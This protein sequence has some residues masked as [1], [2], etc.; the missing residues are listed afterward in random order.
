M[1]WYLIGGSQE[2]V[3]SREQSATVVTQVVTVNDVLI[4]ATLETIL[5]N[6][7]C[8]MRI[9][10]SFGADQGMVLNVLVDTSTVKFDSD[11]TGA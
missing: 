3:E 7:Q 8:M 5:V 4:A 6:Y 1:V 2:R 11:W 10:L 9:G